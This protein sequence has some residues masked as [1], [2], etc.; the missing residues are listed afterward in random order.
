MTGLAHEYY[1]APPYEQN[2]ASND[3]DDDDL[4]DFH[5]DEIGNIMYRIHFYAST[6]VRIAQK[7][8]RRCRCL[9]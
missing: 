3:D 4:D 5:G 9:R 2:D 7:Q 8:D 1:I 6:W